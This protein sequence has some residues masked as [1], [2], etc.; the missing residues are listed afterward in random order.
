MIT[1]RK[2]K[3]TDFED[4]YR[5]WYQMEEQHQNK[6]FS[7]LIK[8]IHGKKLDNLQK[9]KL[10]GDYLKIIKDK[11]KYFIFAIENKELVGFIEVGLHPFSNKKKGGAIW[12]LAIDKDHRK[13]GIATKLKKEGDKWFKKQKINYVRIYHS[14][15]NK[16]AEKIYK[17][18]GFE[19]DNVERVTKLK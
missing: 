15:N 2:G 9:S 13:R 8:E 4:Y 7:K 14:P 3:A 10:K 5:I 1:I 19:I 11:K 6:F 18:W 12:D 16:I 17:K